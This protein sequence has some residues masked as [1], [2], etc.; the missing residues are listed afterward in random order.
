MV[1]L[2]FA[3]AYIDDLLVLSTGY[4][5]EHLANLEEVLTRLNAA[6]LKC[7]MRLAKRKRRAPARS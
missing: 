4:F 6:G 5:D 3:Q 1:G 7:N 2:E